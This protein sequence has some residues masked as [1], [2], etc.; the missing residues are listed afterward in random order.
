MWR[1]PICGANIR[2][3]EVRT[4]VVVYDDAPEVDGDISWDD[5]N[6]ARCV[7]CNWNG[8]AGDAYQEP[9]A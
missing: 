6:P 8:P 2:I 4:A 3:F 1:C 7:S 9:A 5:S